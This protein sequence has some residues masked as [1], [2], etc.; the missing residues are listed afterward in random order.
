MRRRSS[1]FRIRQQRGIAA[2][3][4]AM[5][6]MLFVS[7]V[8]AAAS[9]GAVFYTQQVVSRAAGDGARAISL[10]GAA[11]LGVNDPTIQG[12][13]YK[14]LASSLIAPSSVSMTEAG[15]TTWVSSSNNVTVLVDPTCGGVA[16]CA[17]VT[18]KYQYGQ[19]RVLPVV[20]LL[21]W[22]PDTLTASAIVPI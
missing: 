7:V 5:I 19:N 2:I 6:A 8:Y 10:L 4:F 13:V 3:E 15:R 14:S 12:I 16:G 9:F 18:V 20:P 21:S 1:F 17:K 11:T 22:V